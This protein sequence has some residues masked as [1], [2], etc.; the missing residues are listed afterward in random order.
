TSKTRVGLAPGVFGFTDRLRA[1]GQQ[2]SS[3]DRYTFYRLLSQMGTDSGP[4]PPKLN[5]NYVNIDTNTGAI[6]PDLATNFQ[7]WAPAQFVA[8]AGISILTNLLKDATNFVADTNRWALAGT[9][10]PQV[11]PYQPYY[12]ADPTDAQFYNP[13]NY[14]DFT[15]P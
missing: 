8:R 1:A 12:I 14:I 9:V 2:N 6:L 11:D 4:E 15:G 13:S 5:I 7:P 10:N 3:Y